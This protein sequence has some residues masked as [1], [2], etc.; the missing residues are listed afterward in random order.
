M[1]DTLVK[2]ADYM[3]VLLSYL[4]QPKVEKNDDD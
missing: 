4:W 2:S 3:K 1:K